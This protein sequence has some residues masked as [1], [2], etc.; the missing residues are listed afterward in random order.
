MERKKETQCTST[1][2]RGNIVMDSIVAIIVLVVFGMISLFGWQAFTELE[3]DITADITLNESKTIISDTEERYPLVIDGIILFILLGVWL[4]GIVS[5]YVS[6]SHPLLFGIMM[7]ALVFVIIAGM[8]LGNFYEEL[9]QDQELSSISADFPKVHFILTNMLIITL[10][11]SF[12]VALV[13]FAKNK[14]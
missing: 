9:F 7:I 10:V 1:H 11:I 14:G 8:L 4:M 12:S 3:P 6:E 13:F 5:A 2:R